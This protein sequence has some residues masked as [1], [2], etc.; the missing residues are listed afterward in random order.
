MPKKDLYHDVVVDALQ[1]DGWTITDDP[2]QV[3]IGDTDL[4]VDLAAS[5][6][7]GRPRAT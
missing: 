1:E 4:Y 6:S 5:E 2:L 3:S 7:S